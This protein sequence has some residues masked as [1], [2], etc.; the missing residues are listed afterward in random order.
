[1]SERRE[2]SDGVLGGLR[3]LV[4]FGDRDGH[5]VVDLCLRLGRERDLDVRSTGRSG[6]TGRTSR[7]SRTA[8]ALEALAAERER[9]DVVERRGEASAEVRIRLVYGVV[10]QRAV[11]AVDVGAVELRE[12]LLVGLECAAKILV[13]LVAGGDN[14]RLARVGA[15]RDRVHRGAD[16]VL[17]VL[18]RRG[19]TTG[20]G[21]RCD[22]CGGSRALGRAKKSRELGK[23]QWASP[24]L[25]MSACFLLIADPPRALK[26]TGVG[27]SYGP[28]A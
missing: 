9:R 23:Q 11:G 3:D 19:D 15:P 27:P 5:D 2:Q 8:R 22:N 16:G 7:T 14:G 6:G 25:S 24:V 26:P 20:E 17:H 21:G 28:R 4:H 18:V 1:M 10:E 13:C 12:L